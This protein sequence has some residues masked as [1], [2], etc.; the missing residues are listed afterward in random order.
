MQDIIE[1]S[2][3]RSAPWRAPKASMNQPIIQTSLASPRPAGWIQL[4]LTSSSGPLCPPGLHLNRCTAV[5]TPARQLIPAGP[6][7]RY[8]QGTRTPY[9]LRS[10]VAPKR[11]WMYQDNLNGVYHEPNLQSSASNIILFEQNY[12]PNIKYHQASFDI[13]ETNKCRNKLRRR[14]SEYHTIIRTTNPRHAETSI[15]THQDRAPKSTFPLH[16]KAKP[17]TAKRAQPSTTEKNKFSF[18]LGSARLR[19]VIVPPSTSDE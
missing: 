15:K 2:T 3:A 11:R 14:Y 9:G 13:S 10:F 16:T 8:A 4:S 12:I 6:S 17:R 5:V 19:L 7:C 18:R 1:S